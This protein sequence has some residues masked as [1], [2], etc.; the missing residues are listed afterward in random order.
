MREQFRFDF[1]KNLLTSFNVVILIMFFLVLLASFFTNI[2]KPATYLNTSKSLVNQVSATIQKNLQAMKDADAKTGTDEH[3]EKI[4]E[5]NERKAYLQNLVLEYVAKTPDTQK[6]NQLNLDYAQYNLA[7]IK[8][9]KSADVKLIPYPG[10]DTTVS[11]VNLQKEI[12]FYQYLVAH[13]MAEVPT[14]MEHLPATNYLSYTLAYKIPAVLL[15]VLA[16]LQMAQLFTIE[17][18]NGTIKFLNNVPTSKFRLVTSKILSFFALTVPLFIVAVLGVLIITGLKYG[19]G[20]WRYPLMYSPDGKSAAIMTLGHFLGRYLLLLLMAVIFLATLSTLI[21]LFTGNFGLVLILTC[22]PLLLTQSGLLAE[23]HLAPVVKFLPSAYFDFSGILLD[24][25]KWPVGSLT[26][27]FGV[28][29]AW[30]VVCYAF[31]FFV[32]RRREKI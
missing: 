7:Q 15:L 21:S 32:L 5:E 1:K 24:T 29:V 17:K 31:S 10:H 19:F 26:M 13:K 3:A 23:A 11:T 9:G 8:A 20:S 25:T 27:A 2:S 18:Q 16:C 14:N 30:S 28:L 22:L 6:I 4:A 12:K